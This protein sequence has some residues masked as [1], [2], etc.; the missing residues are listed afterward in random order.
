VKVFLD[1]VVL[2]FILQL[3]EILSIQG[4]KKITIVIV[5]MAQLTFFL[6]EGVCVTKSYDKDGLYV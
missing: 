6:M 4:K 1:Y 3:F 5:Y 2:Y